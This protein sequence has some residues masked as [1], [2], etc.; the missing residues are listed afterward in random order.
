VTLRPENID[1][2]AAAGGGATAIWN[3]VLGGN[4]NIVLGAI[5]ALL[6][7]VVLV[8]RYLINRKELKK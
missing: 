4:L 3:F 5:V 1:T 6:S 8:Q 2:A 7:I